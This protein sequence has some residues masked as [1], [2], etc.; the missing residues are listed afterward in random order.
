MAIIIYILSIILLWFAGKRHG[1]AIRLKHAAYT[2]FLTASIAIPMNR[3][4][5]KDV[6]G[7]G[8]RLMFLYGKK[9]QEDIFII[10][11]A[12]QIAS[13]ILFAS[14]TVVY[15]SIASA[16]YIEL[17]IS[18]M[19]PLVGFFLPDIDLIVKIKQKNSSILHDFPILCTDLAVM[20][21]AG[22]GLYKAWEMA[23]K[24]KADSVLYKEARLVIL[25]T[26]TGMLFRD[27]LKDFSANLSIPEIHTF[28]T[29]VNQEIKSGSGG[30]ASKLRECANKSWKVRESIARKKGEEAVSKL[31]FPLA[32]GLAGILLILAAPAVMIM[33]GM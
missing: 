31:V 27:A 32:V 2:S 29:I 3:I 30:M 13:L 18:C 22:L 11:W 10:H 8:S 7:Y 16:G 5:K 19:M 15:L 4:L 24:R 20:N 25:K 1:K 28:V 33:K 9:V 26:T 23:I 14:F 12:A 17:A 6:L 21:G